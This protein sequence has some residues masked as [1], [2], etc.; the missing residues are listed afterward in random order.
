[1]FIYVV[2]INIVLLKL[3]KENIIFIGLN[4]EAFSFSLV[5]RLDDNLCILFHLLTNQ[6]GFFMIY[7]LAFLV[8]KDV[9]HAVMAS[10]YCL[11]WSIFTF[12]SIFFKR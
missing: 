10:N 4:K 11:F 6:S 12:F 5:K 8:L 1:M 7:R 9:P 2:L 3:K